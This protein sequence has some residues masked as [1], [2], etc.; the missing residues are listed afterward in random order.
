MRLRRSGD[1]PCLGS[2]LSGSVSSPPISGR[3][4]L[5]DDV[6]VVFETDGTVEWLQRF[7]NQIRHARRS[8]SRDAQPGNLHR[9]GKSPGVVDQ[10]VHDIHQ[11]TQCLTALCITTGGEKNVIHGEA[12]M[13]PLCSTFIRPSA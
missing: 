4:V 2:S 3:R 6:V 13:P 10:P 11:S 7:P 5:V 9:A 1:P 12:S 8:V